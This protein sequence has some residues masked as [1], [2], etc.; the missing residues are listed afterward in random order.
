MRL[1]KRFSL[2]LLLSSLGLFFLEVP[3][4]SALSE[5]SA[6]P[7][8]QQSKRANEALDQLLALSESESVVTTQ[9][10]FVASEPVASEPV[11]SERFNFLEQSESDTSATVSSV[12]SLT[13]SAPTVSTPVQVSQ[14]L[15]ELLEAEEPNPVIAP[16]NPVGVE[17]RNER[18]Q[19]EAGSR[20]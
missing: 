6:K 15:D 17:I 20:N 11:A 16:G 14:S 19:D 12:A 4:Q 13:E 7:S 2:G 10:E 9:G 18:I 3:A 1:V 8:A 5:G